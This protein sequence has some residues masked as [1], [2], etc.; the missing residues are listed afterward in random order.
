[1]TSKEAISTLQELGEFVRGA[2]STVEPP[3]AKKLKELRRQRHR[4]SDHGAVRFD[5]ARTPR[6]VAVALET[7][8]ALEAGGWK[9]QR[10]TAL[11]QHAGDA[12][13]IRRATSAM[14][15]TGRCEIVTLHAGGT[16]VAGE[17]GRASCRERV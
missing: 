17:I 5:V 7:F 11:S 1:M 12:A 3:V 6:A 4:L 15:E 14:A 8:L 13:F 16:A 10:G 9:G 2:S